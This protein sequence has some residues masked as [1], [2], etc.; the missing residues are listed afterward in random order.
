MK[1]SPA[2]KAWETMRNQS[3]SRKAVYTKKRKK[4]AKKAAEKLKNRQWELAKVKYLKML[5]ERTISNRCVVCGD[6]RPFVLQ[7]HH[8]DPDKKIEV[9]LCANC[10]DTVRRG[11]FEDLKK[12]HN[13]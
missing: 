10:H 8:A 13:E 2:Q 5:K 4:S 3:S 1:K 9:I 11:T 12:A 6:N 7:I